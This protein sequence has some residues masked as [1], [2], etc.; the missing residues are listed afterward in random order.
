M[1]DQGL[2]IHPV[3]FDHQYRHRDVVADAVRRASTQQVVEEAM[4]VE[5]RLTTIPRSGRPDDP[6]DSTTPDLRPSSPFATPG[7]DGVDSRLS[8]D[9][10]ENFAVVETIMGQKRSL[11]AVPRP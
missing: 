1:S 4:A 3:R 2:G 10:D 11:T 9:D 7:G 6:V 5:A 8:P